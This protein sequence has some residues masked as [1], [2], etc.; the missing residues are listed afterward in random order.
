MATDKK[1][2]KATPKPVKKL[3]ATKTNAELAKEV[4]K[5]MQEKAEDGCPFC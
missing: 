2:K 4:Q 3:S 1:V 5:K